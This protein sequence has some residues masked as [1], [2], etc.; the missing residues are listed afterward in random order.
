MNS[1][2]ITHYQL[3]LDASGSMG[4]IRIETLNSVNRQ[5][6]AIREMAQ[7]N[8]DQK[9][10]I[11]L[12]LF[13]TVTRKAFSNLKPEK[14]SLLPQSQYQTEGSTALLD[15]IGL[16]IS[17]LKE[18]KATEDDVVMVII[19]D[20]EE[21]ASQYFSFEQ[22]AESI[23]QLKAT[24]QWTFTFLG[25]D[26]DAWSI[27]SRLQIDRD[28]VKS[29]NKERIDMVMEENTVFLE[30][31]MKSKREGKRDGFIKDSN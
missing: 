9:L 28:E 11:S 14:T 7:R 24:E 27:A 10:K 8:P 18:N 29:F 23:R 21:N 15:A 1:N 17:D 3:I 5:I 13:N 19:T 12:T 6:E 26:I 2:S 30:K 31:Y 25:A 22:I 16:S 4:S 20:G